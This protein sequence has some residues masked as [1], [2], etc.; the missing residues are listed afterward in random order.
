MCKYIEYRSFSIGDHI[1]CAEEAQVDASAF[2][3]PISINP[4]SSETHF[5]YLFSHL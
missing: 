5:S 1:H 3:V 4:E 2:Y